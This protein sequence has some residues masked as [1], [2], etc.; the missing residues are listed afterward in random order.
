M[1]NGLFRRIVLLVAGMS[2]SAC[3]ANANSSAMPW[4]QDFEKPELLTVHFRCDEESSEYK[5]YMN[6]P[7]TFTGITIKFKG[8]VY[9]VYSPNPN[10]VS[11]ASSS[12][13]KKD[14]E[15]PEKVSREGR[16]LVLESQAPKLFAAMS[17]GYVGSCIIL[18]NGSE[19]GEKN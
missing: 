2:L 11:P 15:N 10:S 9:Y 5:S 1:A 14:G 13:L 12:F 16:D 7:R 4:G 3:G 17:T 18:L 8:G 19:R 6:N